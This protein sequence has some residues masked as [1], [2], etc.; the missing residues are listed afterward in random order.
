MKKLL[1]A[2][3]LN[4]LRNVF[5]NLF[6]VGMANWTFSQSNTL[7]PS[8]NVGIGTTTPTSTLQVNGSTRIDSSLV[9]KDSVV[10][11]KN[12]RI[13]SDLKV[14]G[15]TVLK[16]DALVKN[17]FKVNGNTVLVNDVVIKEGNLKIKSLG[18]ST[19]PGKGI[20]LINANGKVINGGD[21]QELMYS[22]TVMSPAQP[23][24][25]D[26]NGGIVYIAPTWEHDP[27]RMFL[28]NDNC[29][30][31]SKLGVGVK[32]EAKFH[33]RNNKNSTTIPIL[34]DKSVQGSP[35]PYKLMELDKDGLLY[36]RK[37]KVNLDNWP[38]YVFETNYPLLS[39]K[40]I[41]S[42]I[43]SNGHLPNVP[44]AEEVEKNG[45]DLGEANKI[46][47][48]KVEELTLHLIE[49][50]KRIEALENELK[51]KNQ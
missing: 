6:F 11:H 17:D 4:T 35:T 48:Q 26:M 46:L 16:S 14:E 33:V 20:L 43:N 47:L 24:A 15:N 30:P 25:S 34:V 51:K 42:Y 37:M 45:V 27:Q 2:T 10:I 41:E 3:R 8:G 1:Q 9:V 21:P 44:S 49:Q 31:D 13:K 19:L 40:E 38:D 32:P 39:L 29:T 7:P 12:A 36:A 23:C 5:F 28:L 50:N 22:K 18:D